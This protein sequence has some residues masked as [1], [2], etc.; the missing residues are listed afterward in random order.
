[1]S[2]REL[3]ERADLVLEYGPEAGFVFDAVR[4]GD[5][6]KIADALNKLEQ[7]CEDHEQVVRAFKAIQAVSGLGSE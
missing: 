3:Q 7:K 2:E 6:D 4:S 5:L 1:M